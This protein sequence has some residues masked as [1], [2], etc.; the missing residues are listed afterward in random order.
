M[1]TVDK[2]REIKDRV[3][4]AQPQ[5][6][7]SSQV[8]VQDSTLG[9]IRKYAAAKQTKNDTDAWKSYANAMQKINIG[10]IV[11]DLSSGN[12]ISA[13]KRQQYRTQIAQYRA[14]YDNFNRLSKTLSPESYKDKAES[15]KYFNELNNILDFYDKYKDEGQ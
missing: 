10:G 14:N 4:S 11:S 1:I 8:Q 15:D 13:G 12:Y 9:M 3:G 7:A 6:S 2:I 5:T